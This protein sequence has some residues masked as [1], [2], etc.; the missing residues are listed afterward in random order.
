MIGRPRQLCSSTSVPHSRQHGGVENSYSRALGAVLVAAGLAFSASLYPSPNGPVSSDQILPG[1][2][3]VPGAPEFIESVAANHKID[4]AGTALSQLARLAE[5]L[6]TRFRAA[7]ADAV[8]R[9]VERFGL[10]TA[11]TS[12]QTIAA[13]APSGSGQPYAFGGGGGGGAQALPPISLPQLALFLEYLMQRYQG[14]L[15]QALSYVIGYVIPGQPPATPDPHSAALPLTVTVVP[16]LVAPTAIP[17]P[18]APVEA[19]PPPSATPA[20][21]PS[22]APVPI[23]PASV[24]TVA[25][26]TPDVPPAVPAPPAVSAAPEPPVPSTG[27]VNV[28]E[29]PTPN[30]SASQTDTAQGSG[31]DADPAADTRESTDTG[32]HEGGGSSNASGGD[33]SSQGAD[34]ESSG[35]ESHASGGDSGSGSPGGG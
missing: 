21:A 20:P 25:A 26:P 31:R 19:A 29:E 11:T 8:L 1:H 7:P 33:G 10:A 24:E 14:S 5:I 23:A 13:S 30:V 32:R 34:R 28:P 4:F 18:A 3:S 16:P 9:L 12:L 35:N 6:D 27:Q 22:A 17:T 2:G 15:G